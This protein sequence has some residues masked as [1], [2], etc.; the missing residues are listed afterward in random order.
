[1]L[2]GDA[3]G[4][5]RRFY[6]LIFYLFF[7]FLNICMDIPRLGVKSE[8]RLLA[9]TTAATTPDPSR[10]CHLHHSSWQHQIFNPLGKARD[11][12]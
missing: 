6:L 8:L 7:A 9:Y 10:V 1:M 4:Q 2:V 11:Q 12:T 5:A 3:R